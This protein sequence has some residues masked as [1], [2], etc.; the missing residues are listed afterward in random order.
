MSIFFLLLI[1]IAVIVFRWAIQSGRL[2]VTFNIK[3]DLMPDI[4]IGT[5]MTGYI[6]ALDRSVEFEVTCS[7]R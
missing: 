7:F 6:P 4:H 5:R 1:L 2:W 3:E